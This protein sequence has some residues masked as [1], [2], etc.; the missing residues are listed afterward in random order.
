MNPKKMIQAISDPNLSLQER[1]FRLLVMIGLGGLAV[2]IIVGVVVGENKANTI[3]LI[4]AFVIFLCITY[5]S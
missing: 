3:P 1:M 4:I 5:L 2:G